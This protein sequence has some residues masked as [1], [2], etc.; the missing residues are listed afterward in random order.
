MEDVR[1]SERKRMMIPSTEFTGKASSQSLPDWIKDTA[2]WWADEQVSDGD[3][4][5]GIQYLIS[6]GII[7][8]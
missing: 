2:L 7:R 6:R 3:F 1:I 4:V 5:N 8:V